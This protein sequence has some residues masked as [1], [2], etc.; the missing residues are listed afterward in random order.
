MR[1]HC[2]PPTVG[3]RS[4][5]DP[6]FRACVL[7]ADECRCAVC[8]F[9]VRLASV[10]VGIEV[11]HI[12]WHQAGGPYVEASRFALCALRHKL[13]D[14]GA[15]TGSAAWRVGLSGQL[16]GSAGFRELLLAD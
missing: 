7:T 10:S 4:L 14:P 2:Q 5:R 11:A 6:T 16:L 12:K 8:G 9:D 13:F 1:A 15:F 3:A